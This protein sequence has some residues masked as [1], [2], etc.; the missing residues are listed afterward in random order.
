[1]DEDK[2]AMTDGSSDGAPR[3]GFPADRG[4]PLQ[5]ATGRATVMRL[6]VGKLEICVRA[7]LA[8]TGIMVG[9]TVKCMPL[10]SPAGPITPDH[11][12]IRHDF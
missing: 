6:R 9:H 12:P 10:Q 5:P 8:C 7:R 11:G 4:T 2:R 1:M 3:S